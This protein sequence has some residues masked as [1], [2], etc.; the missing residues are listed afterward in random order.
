M[1][2]T[3]SELTWFT[4][5]FEAGHLHWAVASELDRHEVIV[6]AERGKAAAQIARQAWQ[7]HAATLSHATDLSREQVDIK[8]SFRIGNDFL[9]MSE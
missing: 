2:V 6:A 5:E 8:G 1:L 4:E 7:H 9:N 3:V